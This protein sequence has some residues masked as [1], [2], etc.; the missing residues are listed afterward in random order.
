[1]PQ[2]RVVIVFHAT[3]NSVPVGF[4]ATDAAVLTGASCQLKLTPKFC[5]ILAPKNKKKKKIRVI[6]KTVV[7]PFNT[8]IR[9]T[10]AAATIY[11]T[12]TRNVF[13]VFRLFS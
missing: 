13:A 5:G 3:N 12:L 8:V 6:N 1:M 10:F 2:I 7:F 4:C 9:A 11:V